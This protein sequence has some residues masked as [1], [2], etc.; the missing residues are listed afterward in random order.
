[1]LVLSRVVGELI[2]IG[3]D[4]TVR[5]GQE[6]TTQG[7]HSTSLVAAG[8]G[9]DLGSSLGVVGPTRMDYATIVPR[10]QYIMNKTTDLLAEG[11]ITNG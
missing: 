2:S 5:I 1:M 9:V 11:G 4:I 10:A 6:N 8:Y 7:F 3:D